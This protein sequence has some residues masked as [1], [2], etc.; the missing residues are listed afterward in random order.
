LFLLA[1]CGGRDGDKVI[2][3][4][5]PVRL[6]TVVVRVDSVQCLGKT[7]RLCWLDGSIRNTATDDVTIDGA[8]QR[9]VDTRGDEHRAALAAVLTT[10]GDL[11]D[12]AEA[13]KGMFRPDVARLRGRRS[14][15]L[16]LAFPVTGRGVE[17]RRVELTLSDQHG[18]LRLRKG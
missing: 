9:L 18:T 5:K 1:G 13:V 14:A 16:R 15:A 12:I 7:K 10:E 3:L 8:N 17:A 6:G 11:S 2:A 4:G